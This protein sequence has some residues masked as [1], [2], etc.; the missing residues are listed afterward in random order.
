MFCGSCSATEKIA[1]LAIF[2]VALQLVLWCRV[3]LVALC[4]FSLGAMLN[5]LN[6]ANKYQFLSRSSLLYVLNCLVSK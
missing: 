5:A 4:H 3:K 1:V 2:S 6:P